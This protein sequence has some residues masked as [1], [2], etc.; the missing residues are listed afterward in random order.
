M[1]TPTRSL[2]VYVTVDISEADAPQ[3]WACAWSIVSEITVCA[4]AAAIGAFFWFLCGGEIAIE[5]LRCPAGSPQIA[6]IVIVTT[7]ITSFFWSSIATARWWLSLRKDHSVVYE[8]TLHGSPKAKWFHDEVLQ[9]HPV[10]AT[11]TP[12]I[13]SFHYGLEI[14]AIATAATLVTAAVAISLSA[15]L[16]FHHFRPDPPC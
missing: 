9:H 6:K 8:W 16:H 11:L 13:A 7:I 2:L 1:R 12:C 14:G 3:K 10:W 4:L 5:M 15:W